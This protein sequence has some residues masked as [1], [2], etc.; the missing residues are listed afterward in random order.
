[1]SKKRKMDK[2]KHREVSKSDRNPIRV[3]ISIGD[4]NGIGPEIIIKAFSDSQMLVECTPIIYGSTKTMSFHKKAIQEEDFNY[5]RI[6]DASAA[7]NG[8]VNIV[9]IWQEIIDIKLGEAN[10]TGGTYALKS[11]E[12]ATKGG[13]FSNS[14]YF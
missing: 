11:L 13:C 3:G 6:E 10:A 5:H 9:A 12:A 8:K 4:I 1:L 7:Q 2:R 14:S